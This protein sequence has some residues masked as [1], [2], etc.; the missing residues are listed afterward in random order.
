MAE[1]KAGQRHAAQLAQG[2]VEVLSNDVIADLD[3][4]IGVRDIFQGRAFEADRRLEVESHSRH[5]R[6]W[7]IAARIG[8][9]DPRTG[10]IGDAA[11]VENDARLIFRIHLSYT[12]GVIVRQRAAGGLSRNDEGDI[13]WSK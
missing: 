8:G 10:E 2:G 3:H 9:T 4:A 5:E 11:R 1:A 6:D 7:R 13:L 12:G